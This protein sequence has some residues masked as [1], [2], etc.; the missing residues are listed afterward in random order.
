MSS[1]YR[2]SKKRTI[3]LV[4]NLTVAL[5]L[6]YNGVDSFVKGT[7]LAV[8]VLCILSLYDNIFGDKNESNTNTSS[9]DS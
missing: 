7:S 4:F 1:N 2:F 8:T 3:L 5:F 9:I 6:F